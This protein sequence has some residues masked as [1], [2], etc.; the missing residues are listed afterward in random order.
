MGRHLDI[1]TGI[2]VQYTLGN[3]QAVHTGSQIV[4]VLLD[5]PVA[6]DMAVNRQEVLEDMAARTDVI[7]FHEQNRLLLY[8]EWTMAE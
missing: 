5:R 6:P 2:M 4:D 1:L 8:Q 7:V 3:L